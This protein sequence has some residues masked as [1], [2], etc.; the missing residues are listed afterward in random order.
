MSAGKHSIST[1]RVTISKMPPCSLTPCGSPNVCT[2]TRTRMRTSIAMRSRSTCS[3]APSPDPL[4][5]PSAWRFLRRRRPPCTVKIVLCPVSERRMRATCL[6]L[7][8]SA[9][10]SL[11]RRKER[12]APC[13]SCACAARHSC[14]A[15]R[16]LAF[17]CKCFHTLSLVVFPSQSLN[18]QFADR[19]LFVNRL[20][21]ARQQRRHAQHLDLRHLLR[22]RRSAAPNR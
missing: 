1:S 8:A 12:R 16:G 4:A 3:N 7:T 20:N 19:S 6:A 21:A 11:R 14:R 10:A 15:L 22:R 2:G 9:T 18:E 13:P 5:S 17:H